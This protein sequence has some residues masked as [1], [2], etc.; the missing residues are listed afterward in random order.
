MKL[1]YL[2]NRYNNSNNNGTIYYVG[3]CADRIKIKLIGTYLIVTRMNLLL[4]VYS[5]RL[6]VK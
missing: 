5:L 2:K 3:S 4:R 6:E 1:V